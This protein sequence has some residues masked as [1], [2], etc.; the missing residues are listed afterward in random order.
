MSPFG[1]SA[2]L[3]DSWKNFDCEVRDG[4]ATV[5]LNRPDKLDALTFDACARWSCR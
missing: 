2:R 3:A 1:A 5:A 4:G